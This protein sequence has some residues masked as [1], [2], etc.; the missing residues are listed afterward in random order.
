MINIGHPWALAR[1]LTVI[2]TLLLSEIA[3][4]RHNYCPYLYEMLHS[5]YIEGLN[6]KQQQ[7]SLNDKIRGNYLSDSDGRSSVMY[8]V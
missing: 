6:K 3:T 7:H 8:T 1:L 4:K 5:E 2:I